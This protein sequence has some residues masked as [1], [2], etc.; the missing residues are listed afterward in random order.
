MSTGILTV[1]MDEQLQAKLAQ[2]AET[3]GE[4]ESA[5]AR[6]AIERYVESNRPAVPG[7]TC[8]DIARRLGIVGMIKDGPPD[9]SSNPK[10]LE[11]M[12]RE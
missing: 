9:M 8:L 1:E 12:G 3:R 5:I 7:E 10:Y 4:T 11:G 2:L 6:A